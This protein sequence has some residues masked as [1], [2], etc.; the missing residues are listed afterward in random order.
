[1]SDI[2]NP[3]D[4][5]FKEVLT[6]VDAAQDVARHYLPPAIVQQLNL[7]TME[8]VKDS[9][10]DPELQEYFA[11]VLYRL[12][13]LQPEGGGEVYLFILFEHKS[14]PDD[15]ASFQYQK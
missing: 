6:R 8:L 7:E 10:V 5:L 15:R 3:H 13:W 1:M 9:W 4:R 12:E 2:Q 11:D 14:Y